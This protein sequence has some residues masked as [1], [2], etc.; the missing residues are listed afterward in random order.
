[1]CIL[2]PL[3]NIPKE[4]SVKDPR[5]FCLESGVLRKKREGFITVQKKTCFICVCLGSERKGSS[6]ENSRRL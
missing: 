4:F 3:S 2:A 6:Q 1:M 5:L